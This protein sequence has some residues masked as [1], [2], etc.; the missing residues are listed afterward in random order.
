MT[1][2]GFF[3]GKNCF[4]KIGF[5]VVLFFY[6]S[7]GLA[8]VGW[9]IEAEI[10]QQRGSGR[11]GRELV[12]QTQIEPYW[13]SDGRRFWY[14][15]ELRGGGREYIVVDAE[16]GERAAGFD[17]ERL[18]RALRGAGLEDVRGDRLELGRLEFDVVRGTVAFRVGGQ[19]WLCDLESYEIR[20]VGERAVSP[21]EG[22]RGFSAEDG[23]RVSQRTGAET[24]VTFVNQ[25]GEE[26]ELFWL[27]NIGR[28][29]SYGKL[30]AGEE[31]G[32]HTYAGHVWEVVG[33]GGVV[34][35]RFQAEAKRGRAVITGRVQ[36]TGQRKEADKAKGRGE[37]S[38]DG[39]WSAFIRDSN[40]FVRSVEGG[41]EIQLSRDGS[42]DDSYGMVQWG[43]DSNRLV[44]FRIKAGEK[45]EVHL[46]E[47][48]PSKGG[49]AI[50]G[51]RA[52]ALPGD[53]FTSYEL[54]LFDVAGRKQI[55]PLVDRIDFGRPRV[56]WNGDGSRLTYE[57]TDRG[58]QRFRI[59]E[60]DVQSGAVRTLVDE[61][62]E[63]FIWTAHG[64][65][66]PRTTYLEQSNEILYVSE[67]DGWR[68]LYLIDGET[69]QIANQIT[70]GEWVVR[71][72]DRV[73]EEKRQIWFRASGMNRGEDPYLVHF[74]RVNFNGSGLVA[75]TEGNG[76]HSV[77]YS[78]DRKW[79]IDSYSRVDLGAVHELRRVSDGKLVC[80]LEQADISELQGS[81]W[82]APEVFRAKG[83][84]G[85]TD[86]WGIIS[87]PL[88][89]DPEK[90]Y[91]V[92][93]D[94]YAGPHGSH[95]PKTFSTVHRYRSLTELGFI[96]VKID[97]MGTANRSKAF[98][99][100]CWHNLKDAGFADRILWMQ[101]AAK[102]Y[103]YMDI[104]RV[105]I[106]GTSAGGQS[107]A[108]AVLFHPE[109]YKAAVASC[110]CHDN[111]M[112]KASWNEQ[113]MG[114]PVG[115]HYSESSNIDNAHRLKGKLLLMVG[116][117]D[118][119]VPPE[120]T[121]RFVDALIKAEK[122]FD[123]LVVP[124]AGHGNGGSY[125][126]RRME[127]FF[128]RHLQGVEPPDRNAGE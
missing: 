13:F 43:G 60:I 64:P 42:G 30:A 119:N 31:R 99:D 81:G 89:F 16:R 18:A 68:H 104:E 71:G 90:K 7:F 101:A 37:L 40:V 67:R 24:R 98:H 126:K 47:S 51:S 62:T 72:I 9:V 39:K 35:V 26:V 65:G 122:D 15:N 96:V 106:Y 75:L 57:K 19:D 4:W 97:G 49:R 108:G 3:M 115:E 91:P 120:S 61:K 59:I 110:G 124:G 58:H 38:G 10:P 113:W 100:V 111:R 92:I 107:A 94:I 93:E 73:D 45:K 48:S 52:Y 32:Q 22:L 70:R 27:D 114:Y 2:R 21:G 84:D 41:D 44:A 79:L 63:T 118:R 11:G 78:P 86:I 74:Y 46:I 54:N 83:R 87:R 66:L 36:S 55:K 80:E 34:W 50:L 28:R 17:H 56:R 5:L 109:F 29:R 112:D 14:R 6:S 12:Y 123:L 85:K 77:Q 95:V 127:D 33:S 128:V 23:P 53:R 116:E 121:M 102:K 105:G 69:G 125:G 20:K 25:T 1:C 76:T 82:A 88:K 8:E 117:L 103:P